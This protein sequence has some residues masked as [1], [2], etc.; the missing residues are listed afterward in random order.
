LK[1]P[2]MQGSPD[3]FQTPAHALDPL[4]P[5]LH[6]YKRIWEPA[7]GKGNLVHALT[8]HGHDVVGT[9]I[10]TGHDFCMWQPDEWD[11]IVTNPP[12]RYKQEFLERAYL[13]GKPFAFLMPL[14]TLETEKRQRLFREYGLEVIFVP[15][16]INFETPSGNG[17][18]AWFATAW[19]TWGFDIGRQMTFWQN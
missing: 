19:F 7:C 8:E 17:T 6:K 12:Y 16:R 15:K 13:L 1:P 10:L 14:T 2:L 11:A 18:G 5:H 4:L 3:E 9:D